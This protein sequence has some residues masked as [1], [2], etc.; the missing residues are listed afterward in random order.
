MNPSMSSRG[1]YIAFTS[2]QTG[3]AGETN[4]AGIADV[5]LQFIAGAPFNGT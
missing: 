5:F 4:G 2:Y 3:M 1:N